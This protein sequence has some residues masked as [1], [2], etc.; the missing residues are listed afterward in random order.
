MSTGISLFEGKAVPAHIAKMFGVSENT[1]LTQGVG[2]GFPVFSIRGSKW[3][4]KKGGEETLITIPNT[5][6]AAPAIEVVMLKANPS[7]SKTYY[8]AA[9]VEG[10]DA[11][12]DCFSNDGLKPDPAVQNPQ[13]AT[14]AA[15]K[16]NVW[17]SKISP[18]GK[19]IKACADVRRVACAP[20]GDL[21]Q[22][23]LLRVPGASL[24]DLAKYGGDLAKAGVSYSAVVTKLA[25]DADAAFPKITYKA[26]RYLTADEAETVLQ[27]MASGIVETVVAL[28]INHGTD[29]TPAAGT[30]APPVTMEKDKPVPTTHKKAAAKAAPTPSAEERAPATPEH[31]EAD[32]AAP[33]TDTSGLSPERASKL[34]DILASLG[35]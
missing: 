1:D 34:N 22:V 8:K 9:Y 15:C 29:E 13:C 23:I 6:D 32:A 17:G 18:Q 5:D 12:P 19:Q 24:G 35:S 21:S 20:A 16:Q 3:R 25:F 28:P 30:D 2:I 7:L 4:I 33:A 26:L 31:G 11:E 14:C 27:T 10:S